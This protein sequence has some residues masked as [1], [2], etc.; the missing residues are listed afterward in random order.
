[1]NLSEKDPTRLRWY[2]GNCAAATTVAPITA[3]T[4]TK[5][6]YGDAGCKYTAYPYVSA[7]AGD[8][9]VDGTCY[10]GASYTGASAST[11]VKYHKL[12]A[13]CAYVAPA[14]L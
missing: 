8:T 5:V 14:T 6:V 11:A 2:K 7:T 10:T 13:T 3:A 4:Y 12:A 9:I 1:M